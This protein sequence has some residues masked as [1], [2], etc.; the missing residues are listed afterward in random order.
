MGEIPEFPELTEAPRQDAGPS[1][2]EA[3]P[4]GGGVS[5]AA[6]GGEVPAV[7]SEDLESE[8]LPFPIVAIGGSAGG[9]EACQQLLGTL[10]ADTG[11]AFVL[12]SHL[13]PGHKSHL[14]EI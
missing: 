12:I 14:V 2:A 8:L 1:A 9:L 3:E 6:D 13:A 4:A 5:A 7:E 10:P 11:M